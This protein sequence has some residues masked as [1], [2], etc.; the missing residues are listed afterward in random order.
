MRICLQRRATER[1]DEFASA[2][3]L[4]ARAQQGVRRIGVLM[5]FDENDPE[6]KPQRRRIGFGA[7]SRDLAIG[8]R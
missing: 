8:G 7:Q 6:A 2:W 4:V 5:P 3:P 1:S